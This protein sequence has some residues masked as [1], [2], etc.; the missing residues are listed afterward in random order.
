MYL[1]DKLNRF[2]QAQQNTY[3]IALNEIRGGKKFAKQ[4]ASEIIT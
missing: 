3:H 4:Y 1:N 2:I